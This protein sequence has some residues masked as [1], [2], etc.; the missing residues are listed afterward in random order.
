MLFYNTVIFLGLWNTGNR[1]ARRIARSS[2]EHWIEANLR[3]YKEQNAMF[4]KYDSTRVGQYGGGGEYEVQKGFGWTNGVALKL[5]DMFYT[6]RI[7]NSSK[8]IKG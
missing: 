2:A 6:G 4:E 1:K 7:I 5:I 8:E 3:G